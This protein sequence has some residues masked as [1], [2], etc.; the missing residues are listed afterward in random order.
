MSPAN[1]I[2]FSILASTVIVGQDLSSTTATV[3]VSTVATETA[4]AYTTLCQ[5]CL[6]F[7]TT[8]PGFLDNYTP[9]VAI[10]A[11]TLCSAVAERMPS[12]GEP[13]FKL[14][15]EYWPSVTNATTLQI[16]QTLF[17]C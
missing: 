14:F 5:S 6:S 12:V 9:S 17:F 10:D 7:L 1:I 13:C 15:A 2:L 8:L 16:C 3:E 4:T 11:N